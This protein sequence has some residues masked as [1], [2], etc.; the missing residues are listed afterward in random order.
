[1]LSRASHSS[2][3]WSAR[4]RTPP[5]GLGCQAGR[6][7]LRIHISHPR[8]PRGSGTSGFADQETEARAV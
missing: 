6:L 1:M 4:G 2:V 5:A 7:A 8:D 3:L